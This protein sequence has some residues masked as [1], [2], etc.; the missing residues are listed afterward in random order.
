MQL[1]VSE[2]FG[3]ALCEAMLCGCVPIVSNV[4][5]LPSIAGKFGYV[6]ETKNT[7]KLHSLVEVAREE[8]NSE[9]LQSLREHIVNNFDIAIRE[10]KLK[11]LIG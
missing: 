11:A 9:R 2:G 3:I 10:S 4:G 7:E 8:Y 1:S 5:M 6:L